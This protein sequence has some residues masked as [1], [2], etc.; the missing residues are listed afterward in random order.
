MLYP[1]TCRHRSPLHNAFMLVLIGIC[2]LMLLS[3]KGHGADLSYYRSATVFVNNTDKIGSGV[4]VSP[5]GLIVTAAHVINIPASTSMFAPRGAMKIPTAVEVT[6]PGRNPESARVLAV[7]K[8]GEPTDLAILQCSGTDYPALRLAEASPAVGDPVVSLGY[9]AGLFAQLDG[10]VTFVGL[11]QDKSFDCLTALGRPQPGHSGGPLIDG[12]GQVVGIA[13]K[14]TLDTVDFCGNVKLDEQVGFYARVESIH[15][16][17]AAHG[18]VTQFTAGTGRPVKAFKKLHAT[19]WVQHPCK[20]C[21][22]Q[23]ADFEARLIRINGR[24]INDFVEVTWRDM[25]QFPAEAA[26]AGV[27][28]TPI[29]ICE[30][31]G[32]RIEGYNGAKDFAAKVAVKL[33]TPRTSG[34]R[35]DARVQLGPPG[36]F[37]PL[38]AERPPVIPAPVPPAQ[39]AIVAETKADPV[40]SPKVIDGTGLRVLLLVKRQDVS[41]WQ[42]TALAAVESFAEGGLRS[43]INT[44]L[45]GKAEVVVCFE[46]TSPERFANLIKVTGA[47]SDKSAALVVL[48]PKTFTGALGDV[49][50]VIE[51][52]LKKLTNG[53]WKRA[54]VQLVFEREDPEDYDAVIEAL[55]QSEPTSSGDS[56][57]I[58]AYVITAITSALAGIRDSFLGHKVKVAQS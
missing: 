9:P 27:T 41:F 20:Y 30:E 53:D 4:C 5:N 1:V 54:T 34:P 24:P 8:A 23:R 7:S 42:G 58:Y 38:P 28:G 56:G 55:D 13:C 14:A 36:V 33:T 48:A 18:V 47:D 6:F 12:R 29:T 17:M 16:L 26:A 44:A 45:G 57:S 2:L 31:T 15:E 49:T 40:E 22:Q 11:T 32:D 50:S 51:G 43:R 39:P 25:N 35:V 10:R 3:L 46:R 37:D 19:V 21:D 52:K